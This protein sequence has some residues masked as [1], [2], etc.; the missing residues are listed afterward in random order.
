MKIRCVWEHNGD[1]SILYADNFIG[2]FTR[3]ASKDLA[4]QKMPSEIKSY[5]LW[6]G[7]L[8][9]DF[10]E[11]EIVQEKCSELTIS[12]ADSDV[13]FDEERKELSAS[14]YADLKSLALK[15]AHDFFVLYQAIPDKDKSC[16]PARATFYGQIPR[17]ASEMYEHTKNVNDY[18]FGEIGVAADHEGDI[19]ECRERGF[20]VLESQPDFLKNVV[21]LGSYDEEWSLRKVLRRFIWHDRIH[22]KAMYRMAVK[23]F[24][25]DVVPNIFKFDMI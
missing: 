17:T 8:T 11:T 13:L 3:G 4:I 20:A 16:I 19:V 7:D 23:T 10:F 2:A 21:C 15:S 25:S 1:D 22:A 18:Y 5:L 6:K 14:E 12:D 24:G 9:S